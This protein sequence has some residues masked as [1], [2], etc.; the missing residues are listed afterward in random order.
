[1]LIGISHNSGILSIDDNEHSLTKEQHMNEYL[2]NLKWNRASEAAKCVGFLESLI[3]N[4]EIP[5]YQMEYAKRYVSQY[6]AADKEY[7]D[8]LDE[9][10]KASADASVDPAK[11]QGDHC[12]Y[13]AAQADVRMKRLLT[14]TAEQQEAWDVCNA[15]NADLETF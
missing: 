12:G 10:C 11:W 1:L 14:P 2:N 4:N 8:A 13:L 5:A 15:V 3:E 7:S 9:R 6:N